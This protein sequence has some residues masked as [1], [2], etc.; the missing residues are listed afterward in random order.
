MALMN[1]TS[2]EAGLNSPFAPIFWA[3]NEKMFCTERRNLRYRR[4]S[5]SVTEKCFLAG[6][7]KLEKDATILLVLPGL[8]GDK[9]G[10]RSLCKRATKQ[11]IR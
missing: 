4:I 9:N 5:L 11:S 7:E 6:T 3:A 8:T 2:F 1:Q 10:F